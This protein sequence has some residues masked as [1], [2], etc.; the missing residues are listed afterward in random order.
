MT[1]NCL[2]LTG[3][4]INAPKLSKSP[5]GVVHCKFKLKHESRQTE[6]KYTRQ[7]F[8]I[9]PVVVTGDIASQITEQ[10]DKGSNIKVSG[11]L[12]SHKTQSGHGELVLHAQYIEK[13]F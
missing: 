6:A 7:C 5:A 10:I 4:L 2:L 8:C 3:E 12:T 13:L 9:M 1:E 11:F